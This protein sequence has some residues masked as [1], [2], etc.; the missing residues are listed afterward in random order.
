MAVVSSRGAGSK[1]ITKDGEYAR[2]VDLR[3]SLRS[4]SFGRAEDIQE[5]VN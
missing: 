1:H 5:Q 2:S 3:L 4:G